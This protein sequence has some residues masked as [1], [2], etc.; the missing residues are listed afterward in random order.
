MTQ[1]YSFSDIARHLY[2][3]QINEND[4][5]FV[6]SVIDQNLLKAT[7]LFCRYF[8]LYIAMYK[9]AIVS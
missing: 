6:E 9:L 1:L 3:I 4:F 7:V 5:S 8:D 2:H